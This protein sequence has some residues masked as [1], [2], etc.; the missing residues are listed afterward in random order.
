VARHRLGALLGG[1]EGT[2]LVTGASTWM[3]QAGVTNPTGMLQ[4]LA[5][6][7]GRR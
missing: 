1:D 3:T 7:F 4:M 2:A 6:G 5:P